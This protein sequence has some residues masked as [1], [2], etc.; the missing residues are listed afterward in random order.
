MENGQKSAAIVQGTAAKQATL[1]DL[2][3]R[4]APS[5]AGVAPKHLTPERL[6]KIAL[7]A[8]ARTPEILACSP[9]SILRAVM[10][11]A[12]LGLEVGG[13]LGDAYFVPFKNKTTGRTEAQLIPGYRGLIKL[14]RNSG[15]ITSIEAHVVREND[16][17]DLSYGLDARLHHSPCLKGDP[18]DVVAAYAIAR[19]KDG[20]HQWEVMT[21]AELD[22]IKNRSQ[23]ATSGPWVT[24]EAEMQKKTVIRR[25]CK[26]LP[27]SAEL[28]KAV[29]LDTAADMGQSQAIDVELVSETIVEQQDAPAT[30][31]DA[32]RSKLAAKAGREPGEE[33]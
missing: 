5:L 33:G 17:F 27:L 29:E 3:N 28:A 7:S 31:T 26:Y 12:E 19:F 2:L 6:V 22:A 13:L 15:Q 21:R 4:A 18:G 10:Q 23:A 25:L 20:G 8:A 9:E 32:T 14:A 16:T 24:D 30:R 11:G 1:K